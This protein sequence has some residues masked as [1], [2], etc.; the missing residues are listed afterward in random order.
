MGGEIL[1]WVE[2]DDPMCRLWEDLREMKGNA[3]DLSL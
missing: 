3:L 2:E 1:G